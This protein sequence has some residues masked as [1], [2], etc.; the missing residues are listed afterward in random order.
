[1][2]YVVGVDAGGTKTSAALYDEEGRTLFEA[3]TGH[4]NMTV[5]PDAAILNIVT[6]AAEC[7]GACPGPDNLHIIVGAAGISAE[8][9]A[10]ALAAA[11]KARLPNSP[12]RIEGDAILALYALTK[13]RDGILVISGTGTIAHGKYN[14]V[15]HRIGG[16][17]HILGDEGS[18]YQI[19]RLAFTN[20]TREYDSGTGYGLMSRMLME[21]FNGDINVM[22]KYVYAASKSEIA[23]FLPMVDQAA[24][25]GDETAAALLNDA[26]LYLAGLA[27]IL[28]RR[29][30]YTGRATVVYKGGVIEKSAPV[31]RAFVNAL[32]PE[33]FLVSPE[34]APSELG[35]YYMHFDKAANHSY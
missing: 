15:Q 13:G 21:K 34:S 9:N 31:R 23:G 5:N 20:V 26:G 19:A 1:M 16:W 10:Q 11:F 32:P 17:G 2:E 3:R 18:G 12:V 25:G 6:A 27:E 24:A 35:A 28:W 4:G 33:K 7:V 14:G 22:I 8:G 29:L 30:G